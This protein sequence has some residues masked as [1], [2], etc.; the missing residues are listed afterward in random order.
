MARP[1][2]H[3]LP[4][5]KAQ[6]CARELHLTSRKQYWQWWDANRPAYMPKR[7]EKVYSEWESWNMFLGTN[8]TFDKERGTKRKKTYRTFWEA[9]RYAQQKAKEHNITTQ[10]EWH[11]WHDSG[12]CASDVPKRPDE[13]YA[14]FLGKGWKVWLGKNIESKIETAKNDVAVMALCA[15][16]GQPANVIIRV[17]SSNGVAGLKEK[18]EAGVIGKPYRMYKWER[19]LTAQVDGMFSRHCHKRDDNV[20]VVPNMNA[21]LF[22][23]D[24]VL[25]WVKT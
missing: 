10:K 1:K 6:E 13:V 7:P 22:D 17:V 5:D 8:N 12:M 23:L 3:Y 19:E 14:E 21:L 20:F 18:Y 2:T 9:V 16:P 15:C 24:N 4:Y 25:Q 11:E